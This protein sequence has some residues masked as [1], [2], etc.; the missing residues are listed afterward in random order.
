MVR[1]LFYVVLVFA[2]AA[3]F[4]WLADHPGSLTLAFAGYEIRTSV[5]VAAILL[6]LALLLLGLVWLVLRGLWR[7][8]RLFGSYVAGRRRDRG[9]RALSRGLI[10]IGTGDRAAAE[11][12]AAE[13]RRLLQREPLT[14]LLAAQAAQLAGDGDA[15]RSAFEA[16]LADGETRILGLRGLFVEA[17]RRGDLAAARHFAER[18]MNERP[19]VGWAGV[20]LLD[21][22][23]ADGDWAGALKTLAAN[24]EAK[25]ISKPAAQRLEA[26][27]LTARAMELE[28]SQPESARDLA[29]EAHRLA[30]EL[31]PA[32]VLA[33]RLA[34]RLG[35]IRRASKIIETTWKI[36][37]HPDLAAAYTAVRPGD[38][39]RDRLKRIRALT[40]LRANHREGSF[41]L[42]RA[43]IDAADWP[44]ARESLSGLVAAGP[45]ER[46]CLLMAEIEEREHADIGRARDWLARAVT[47]PRDP[48]WIA[49]E[50]VFDRWAPVS[51]VSGRLDAFEWKVPDERLISRRADIE[52]AVGRLGGAAAAA[53]AAAPAIEHEPAPAQPEAAPV[54]VSPAAAE[55]PSAPAPVPPIVAGEAAKP[56]PPASEPKPADLAGST[57]PED[58]RL[59]RQPDD[60]GP[61]PDPLEPSAKSFRPFF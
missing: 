10:A 3:G 12:F 39:V 42:A 53:P 24:A 54:E 50:V 33:S 57:A 59:P 32:A 45:T 31:V 47:A 19:G 2:I 8:P 48:A 36:E 13:S 1:I 5:L 41:A 38:G 29:F 37:P 27:L 43:A 7:S 51:P 22:Q 35:D 14:L 56:E 16:M 61:D 18:A 21:F 34:S 49:D 44:L 26:V 60:P 58:A 20:A 28:G 52:A 40:R 30:P 23:S 9:Y 6:L 11:R 55:A 4:A 25:V 17:R 46:A 15:A